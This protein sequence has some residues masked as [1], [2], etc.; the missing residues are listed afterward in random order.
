MARAAPRYTSYPPVPR[1]GEVAPAV[2]AAAL[3]RTRPPA[4][5]YVHIPFC[6]SQ[7]DFCG[8]NMVVARRRAAGARYLAALARQIEQL[9]LPADPLPVQRIHLGGGTP[10][11]LTPDELHTLHS[12]LIER[13]SPVAGAELSVEA[14]PH[15]T[16]AAHL[17]RLHALGFNRLSLG[18]Q[19]FDPAVLA[20]VGRAPMLQPVVD[21]V[22]QLRT[23]GGW[24]LSLDLM[25][26][27]PGQTL[28]SLQQT[29]HQT[30]ALRP[31]RISLFAYAHVPWRKHNQRRIDTAAL[32]DA[33]RRSLLRQQARQQLC[34]AGYVPIGFD[35]YALPEDDLALALQGGTLHRNFMGYTT[36][37]EVDLIGLGCSAISE[38]AGVYWQDEPRLRRWQEAVESG[39]PLAAR[40]HVLT[41]DDRLRRYIINSLLCS[42]KLDIS[43]A[44]ARF[45]ARLQQRLPLAMQRL[46]HQD[47]ADWVRL[48]PTHI[49]ITEAGRAQARLVAQLFDTATDTT[50]CS[51]VG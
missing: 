21:L 18:V 23:L 12:T 35:H 36:L 41:E 31:D 5:V 27:L 44:E 2:I 4:Q 37:P 29:L 49:T 39:A 32:P 30:I 42:L 17:D 46:H 48:S 24:G 50:G 11:W 10:T 1:W 25:T 28:G 45:G 38:V 15:V 33:E 14:N 26:G 6:V 22:A 3:A 20:A 51:L 19:S 34:D 47:Y 13:F 7:C 40:G 43:A 9:P 16:S 8:C